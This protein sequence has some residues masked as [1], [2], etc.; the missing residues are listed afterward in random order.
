MIFED[1]FQLNDSILFHI[2][3]TAMLQP[4]LEEKKTSTSISGFGSKCWQEG[5]GYQRLEP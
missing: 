4:G 3:S 2:M 5:L 1:P